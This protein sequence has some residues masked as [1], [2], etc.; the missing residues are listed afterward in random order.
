M[1]PLPTTTL[2]TNLGTWAVP[3]DRLPGV[4]GVLLDALPAE[5]YDPLFQGQALETTYFDT[6]GFD[7]RKAR[8]GRDRYLTLRVRCYGTA[9]YALS[10]KTESEK[11]RAEIEPARAELLLAGAA[12]P[13]DDL[14]GR[15]RARL[16]EL[17]AEDLGPVVTVC[18]RRYAVE[19]D[20][21][22]LTLDVGVHTD[23]G[24]CLPFAVLE[25][26]STDTDGGP[27][28]RLPALRLRPIKL[29][30]FLWSTRP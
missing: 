20:T 29:S 23:A 6:T 24:K 22:R 10:A 4:A 26:K 16:L 9:S 12:S 13:A 27:P 19:D 30:K 2:R 5:V 28:G 14:P 17:G 21:D 15:L 7:L 1:Q 18:C 11:W 8:A 3:T 25:F